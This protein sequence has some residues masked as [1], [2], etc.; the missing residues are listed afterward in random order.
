MPQPTSTRRHTLRRFCTSSWPRQLAIWFHRSFGRQPGF[1]AGAFIPP[2]P[3][4][5]ADDKL[6][7]ELEALRA[8]FDQA[9]TA[10]ERAQAEA[11]EQALDRL[12]AEEQAKQSDEDRAFWEA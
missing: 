8:E 7:K 11:E 9:R 12:T 4:E 10:A 1:K 3:P 2:Q 5:R 6:A